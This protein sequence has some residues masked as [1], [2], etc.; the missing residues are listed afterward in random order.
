MKIHKQR[1]WAAV[2]CAAAVILAVSGCST[3]GSSASADKKGPIV[4]GAAI[5]ETGILKDRKS[6]V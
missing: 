6:V 5:G 1:P 2:V 4:I 3:G